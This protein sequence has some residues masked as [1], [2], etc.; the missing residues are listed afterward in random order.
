MKD[1]TAYLLML[2]TLQS[3]CLGSD[4]SAAT[5]QLYDL[6]LCASVSHILIQNQNYNYS[7]HVLWFLEGVMS[8]YLAQ[9]LVVLDLTTC[10]QFIPGLALERVLMVINITIITEEIGIQMSRRQRGEQMMEREN[11][12]RSRENE[13]GRLYG[14]FGWNEGKRKR[15]FPF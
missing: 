4:S 8:K 3:S 5:Y 1:S 11:A 7:T 13:E 6:V 10:D 12:E 2:Y 9:C 14:E 15:Y